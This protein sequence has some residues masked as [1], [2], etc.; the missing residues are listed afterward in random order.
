[1]EATPPPWVHPRDIRDMFS[2]RLALLTRINDR[3]AH[4][5]LVS[6]YRITLGEWRTLAV[7]QYLGKPSLRAVARATQQDE[8]QLSRYVA[9]LIKRGL[10]T[11]TVSSEDRRSIDLMLTDEAR[12]LYDEVMMV[13]WELNRE[14]FV[15]LSEDEQRQLVQL[16]DKL[17]RS[18]TRL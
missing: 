13:A 3:Q 6:T 4:N 8:G 14:M 11:K 9:G 7:V 16:L 10:L 12:K 2:Y 18:I 1:M 15:D 5:M 17:F